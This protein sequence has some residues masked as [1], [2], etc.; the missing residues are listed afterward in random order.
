MYLVQTRAGAGY[1]RCW[2]LALAHTAVQRPLVGASAAYLLA[3]AVTGHAPRLNGF[4]GASC[5]TPVAGLSYSIYLLQY[6]GWGAVLLPVCEFAKA[7]LAG[8]PL[9]TQAALTYTLPLLALVGT[10]PLALANFLFVERGA[11]LLG[12]RWLEQRA[13]VGGQRD[14]EGAAGADIEEGKVEDDSASQGETSCGESSITG[15]L[16]PASSGAERAPMAD[17]GAAAG[18]APAQHG[19]SGGH[20]GPL[21][22]ERSAC[23]QFGAKEGAF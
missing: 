4:L 9:A 23:Q 8:A 7:N 15:E 13:D 21:G 19:E 14:K 5:W 11:M 2:R 3:L 22:S 18:E 10:V 6:V 17:Q 16:T 1:G 20:G 12:K